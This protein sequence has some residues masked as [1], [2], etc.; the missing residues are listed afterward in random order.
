MIVITVDGLNWKYAKDMYKDIFPEQ[1]MRMIRSNVR[2]FTNTPDGGSPTTV[3]LTCMWSGKHIK[4]LSDEIRSTKHKDNVPIKWVDRNG[5]KLDLIWDYFDKPKFSF[6]HQGPNWLDDYKEFFVHFHSLEN[7]KRTPSDEMCIFA[8]ASKDDWD[9]FWIHTAI[10][11][12][13]VFLPGCY[14]KGRIPSLITYDEIRKDKKLK[15]D[16][17]LFG[18]RRY[19]EVIKWLQ[20]IRPNDIFVISADHGTMTDIPFTPEQIDEIPL[21]VNRKIDLEDI[22]YQWD[23]KKLLLRLKEMEENERQQL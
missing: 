5:K 18:A 16:V 23:F 7:V 19:V 1:S 17:Y 3:G 13:G 4:N 12:G 6:R 22:N 21:I 8:E 9:F 14:D 20:D 2:S 11:K 10:V 15:R